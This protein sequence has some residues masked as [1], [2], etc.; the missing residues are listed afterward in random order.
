M[1]IVT[2]RDVDQFA[3]LERQVIEEARRPKIVGPDA[4]PH[5]DEDV[6][7]GVARRVIGALR[8]VFHHLFD[9][10]GLSAPFCDFLG[11]GADHDQPTV[12]V[13]RQCARDRHDQHHDHHYDRCP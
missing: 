6:D 3:L 8:N 4:L 5:W 13:K 11:A 10:G 7:R 9:R 1:A 2:R 12:A